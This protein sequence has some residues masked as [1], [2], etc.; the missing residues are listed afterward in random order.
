[1]QPPASGY[2]H[3]ARRRQTGPGVSSREARLLLDVCDLDASIAG[4][5][6]AAVL[7]LMLLAGLRRQEVVA[8][9]TGDLAEEDA[10]LRVRSRRRPSRFVLLEG[11]CRDAIDAWLEAR[12]SGQGPL[13][14]ALDVG[15]RPAPRALSAAAINRI[16]ARRAA[17]AGCSEVTPRRLRQRFLTRL[18]AGQSVDGQ[19]RRCA[20][21]LTEDGEPAWTLASLA[22]A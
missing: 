18:R 13:L 15:G 14:L 22:S 10:R 7:A 2:A 4:R 21:D 1:L 16:V 12:G 6:D 11:A 3:A 20:Y 8:L 9:T 19:S 5:R 17:E